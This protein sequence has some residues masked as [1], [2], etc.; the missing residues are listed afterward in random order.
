L[1]PETSLE[2][3]HQEE[4]SLHSTLNIDDIDTSGYPIS[5]IRNLAYLAYELLE[6]YLLKRVHIGVKNLADYFS[7]HVV[8]PTFV[9]INGRH[10]GFDI[11]SLLKVGFNLPEHQITAYQRNPDEFSKVRHYEIRNL[12]LL[13]LDHEENR[14]IMIKNKVK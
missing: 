4:K 7:L 6:L 8:T 11:L 9:A 12:Y 3:L 1:L 14:F 5:L 10:Q 13:T 2:I